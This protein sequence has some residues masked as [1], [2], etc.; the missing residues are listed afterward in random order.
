MKHLWPW[1]VGRI[2][3]STRPWAA[4]KLTVLWRPATTSPSGSTEEVPNSGTF[5][6]CS[7]STRGSSQSGLWSASDAGALD[8]IGARNSL[9]HPEKESPKILGMWKHTWAC[10]KR[11]RFDTLHASCLI[12]W[13]LCCC[14][15]FAIVMAL[16]L[17]FASL[18]LPTFRFFAV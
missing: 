5:F 8:Q 11:L 10:L 13:W 7:T 9:L 18:N 1:A 17:E 6:T 2:S 12:V 16:D 14:F 3:P 4:A 15:W